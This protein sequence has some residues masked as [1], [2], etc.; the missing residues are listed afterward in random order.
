MLKARAQRLVD[1]DQM[2]FDLGVD[3]I[4][5]GSGSVD[6]PVPVTG[7]RAGHLIE[8]ITSCYTALGFAGATDYDEVF[9]HLV[10]ARIIQ[11]G[12]KLD[13]VETLAEVGV[14]PASYSTINRRLPT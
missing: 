14:Q 2:S 5:V 10:M 4:P 1:G 7:E 12:S 8:A 6:T 3:T 9:E 13:S 11:P